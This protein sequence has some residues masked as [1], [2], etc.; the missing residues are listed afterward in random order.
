MLQAVQSGNIA[1]YIQE[2]QAKA[3]SG[4]LG[5]TVLMGGQVIPQGAAPAPAEPQASVADQLT[6]LA[7]L[8]DRGVLTD[9]EFEA[10]KAKLLAGS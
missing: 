1:G 7:D 2:M 3:L 6:K 4:E 10:Q 5:G 8:K 9:A